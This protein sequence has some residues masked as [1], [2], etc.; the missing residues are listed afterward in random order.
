MTMNIPRRN[1]LGG[2]F[3][4][5][6]V[7]AGKH[8]D[9]WS[10][11]PPSS[12]SS[13][14]PC[15]RSPSP[16]SRSS[17]PGNGRRYGNVRKKVVLQSSRKPEFGANSGAF[18]SNP[19]E[20]SFRSFLAEG[21]SSVDKSS[22]LIN[23]GTSD[24]LRELTNRDFLT[25]INDI[26]LETKE[27]KITR[28]PVQEAPPPPPEETFVYE[29]S[30]LDTENISLSQVNDLPP[31]SQLR[32][33][34]GKRHPKTPPRRQKP[35]RKPGDVLHRDAASFTRSKPNAPRILKTNAASWLRGQRCYQPPRKPRPRGSLRKPEVATDRRENSYD[36]DL[37]FEEEEEYDHV[38]EGESE[39]GSN[40]YGGSEDVS[41]D[42]VPEESYIESEISEYMED[43]DDDEDDEEKPKRSAA[44]TKTYILQ[45]PSKEDTYSDS[46]RHESNDTYSP[47]YTN[48]RL[49]TSSSRGGHQESG[50]TSVDSAYTGSRGATPDM[51][52]TST[53]YKPQNQ[54][55]YK[56]QRR[57]PSSVSFQNMYLSNSQ[58]MS[59]SKDQLS[60]SNTSTLVSPATLSDTSSVTD[61]L[62]RHILIAIKNSGLYSD[63][64]INLLLQ[65]YESRYHELPLKDVL[66]VTAE[67]R[68]E[69]RVPAPG[70]TIPTKENSS[71]GDIPKRTESTETQ[72]INSNFWKPTFSLRTLR[73]Y[74]RKEA[75]EGDS[76]AVSP[77]VTRP[78]HVASDTRTECHQSLPKSSG[79]TTSS[80]HDELWA[81]QSLKGLDP[82]LISKAKE[83]VDGLVDAIPNDLKDTAEWTN[84]VEEICN[85]FNIS[86]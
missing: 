17:R 76:V 48:V 62:R 56:D 74:R 13:G 29:S 10:K 47:R 58:H 72:K 52:S 82:S 4:K 9:V 7:F 1:G 26:L 45:D 49:G 41:D 83:E 70:E 19:V 18:A 24:G 68:S 32:L 79:P 57:N 12:R 23:R 31:L 53:P 25:K 78:G 51:G 50:E 16:D 28:K 37:S 27:E 63:G 71:S 65:G 80:L 61:A 8:V 30:L 66:K 81:L 5:K 36:Y 22:Q 20:S 73:G 6:Q 60:G 46:D 43:D 69:L 42:A 15:R 67:V 39:F 77:D 54:L 64:S 85:Q 55:P 75:D 11:K 40:S 59:S 33:S 44:G 84:Y 14:R 2:S 3:G 86:L 21:V 34:I 35:P 38:T